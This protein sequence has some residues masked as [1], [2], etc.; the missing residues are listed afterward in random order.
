MR[1]IS[2]AMRF[3]IICAVSF[4]ASDAI[5]ATSNGKK[6]ASADKM[7]RN[8]IYAA[9]QP[10]LRDDPTKP[11]RIKARKAIRPIDINSDGIMDYQ[12][13]WDDLGSAAWCGTGGCRYQLWLSGTSGKPRRV[14]DQQVRSTSIRK[15]GKETIFDFQFHG[16]SCGGF[17]SQDCPVS[18]AFDQKIGRFDERITPDGNGILRMIDPLDDVRLKRPKAVTDLLAKL[19]NDC[20]AKGGEKGE[21]AGAL[22]SV[23]ETPDIDGDGRR[24]WIVS[25]PKCSA[26]ASPESS[27]IQSHLLVTAGNT[28]GM[29]LA[30]SG[31]QIEL[32]ILKK[33]AQVLGILQTAECAIYAT[34][35]EQKAC[36]RYALIWDQSSRKFVTK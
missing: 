26:D 9:M 6:A 10:D 31:N 30:Y 20:M 11:S 28:T 2:L 7:A 16:G 13:N 25:T 22:G 21:D 8:F 14:F 36:K 17:G 18:F 19:H 32:S 15:S 3:L 23:T 34:E 1:S 29:E 4:P 24:D 12:V 33:P 5:G 35:K 27:D